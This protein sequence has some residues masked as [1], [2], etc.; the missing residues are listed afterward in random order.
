MFKAYLKRILRCLEKITSFDPTH[1]MSM[2][3]LVVISVKTLRI[4]HEY[5]L[6]KEFA[7]LI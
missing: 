2:I 5:S 1:I 3:D 4:D 6:E 7:Q